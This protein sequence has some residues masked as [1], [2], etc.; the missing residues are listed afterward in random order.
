MTILPWHQD[1]WTSLWQDNTRFPS[2]LLLYGL[3]GIGKRQFAQALARAILCQQRLASFESCGRCSSCRWFDNQTHPDYL[4]IAPT[5]S[6]DDQA[7]T[8]RAS[9]L[10]LIDQI[11]QSESFLYR[12]THL[13]GQRV[14][15]IDGAD[16]F[17]VHAANAFLKKLEEPPPHTCY[18]L[19]ADT[20]E[21]ILPTILSRVRAL[22]LTCP[23]RQGAID[24]LQ[25]QHIDH[26]QQWLA[27]SGGA[28]LTAL[29]LARAGDTLSP[30]LFDALSN[31]PCCP[32]TVADTLEQ[33]LRQTKQPLREIVTVWQKICH[34]LVQVAHNQAPR[35]YPDDLTLLAGVVRQIP[36][37]S[38]LHYENHLRLCRQEA[39]H[40]LNTRLFLENLWLQS[41]FI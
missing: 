28:P 35:Y 31:L 6:T 34:D 4:Q 25:G 17:H 5:A 41:P 36:L 38:L 33:W 26:P 13:G 29:A 37:N 10:I 7:G 14:M 15:L 32:V 24:W 12:T 8:K 11:R 20:R 18:I 30:I 2:A 22:R 40:S 3:P 39:T 16:R 19:V 23:D 27:R 9:T 1:A 21:T